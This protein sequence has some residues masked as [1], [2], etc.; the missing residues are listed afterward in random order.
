MNAEAV[1]SHVRN[2]KTLR[3]DI[4]GVIQTVKA[5]A[6][7]REVSLTITKLQEAVMWLGMD[8]KRV[9]EEHPDNPNLVAPYPTGKDPSTPTVEPVADGLKL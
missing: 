6:P 2:I 3:R 5:Q 4:D 9:R 1:A 7:S 8:L